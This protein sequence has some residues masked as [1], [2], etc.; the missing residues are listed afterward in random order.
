[1]N[2]RR[3]ILFKF[4][5]VVILALIVGLISYPRAVKFL[6]AVYE[7][8]NALKI[9]LGLDLQGGIHLEYKADTG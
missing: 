1:M 8:L 3:K 7:R 9:N 2:L 4:T 5:A 6:P